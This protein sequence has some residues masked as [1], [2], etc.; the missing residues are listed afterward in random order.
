MT[1]LAYS[2]LLMAIVEGRLDFGEPLSENDL[3]RAMRLSKAPIRESL[4]E[5]RLRGLVEV[6]PRSG[7]YVFSPTADQIA[8]LCDYRILLEVNAVR[9]SMDR[10][11]AM[12]VADLQRIVMEMAAAHE[13]G[14]VSL[15]NKLDK[16]FHMT[17][18]RH[19]GNRYLTESYE[20]IG[21]TVESLR[22]R[23]MSTSQYR[24]KVKDEHA[25]IVDLL[26]KRQTTKATRL[27]QS[28]I[29][30]VKRVQSTAIWGTGRL[31]RKDYRF[32]DYSEILQ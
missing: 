4:G 24:G 20:H 13:K 30:R 8:E 17:I 32:R 2:K 1:E 3:A 23:I 7:S 15:S 5:L 11:P 25:T 29:E 21:L 28:H 16:Q 19:S 27:L 31:K 22:Y 26:A 9:I 12:L 6:V 14:D 18:I 10:A